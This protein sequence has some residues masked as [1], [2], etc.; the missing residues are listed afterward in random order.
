MVKSE[1]NNKIKAK[2]LFLGEKIPMKTKK[3][4]DKP[5]EEVIK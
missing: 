5:K 1:M 4:I 3:K 2:A